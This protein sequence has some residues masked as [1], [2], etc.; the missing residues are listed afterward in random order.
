VASGVATTL[1]VVA[2]VGGW[3]GSDLPAQLF[4]VELFR[5]Y[6]FVLWDNQ[7]F[8]GH[9]TLGYSVIAP[10]F[11]AFTGPVVLGAVSGVAS[12]VLFDRIVHKSF[13]RSARLGSAW[14]ALSIVTNLVVGRVAFGLG[15]AFALAA[16]LLLQRRRVALAIV[17]AVA[18][19]LAS[20]VAAVFLAI[21][22]AATGCARADRRAGG[23]L[24]AVAAL[25][26]V[27]VIA[28]MFPSPGAEP[29]ELWALVCDLVLC[30]AVF[31][32]AP[33]D[34]HVLRWGASIYAV[35]VLGTYTIAT[36]LGGNV[37]R[38][39]QYIAGP[40]L[41]CLLWPRRRALLGAIAIPLLVWQ[42]LPTV[43]P[44]ALA[45]K[46]LSTHRAYYQPLL[47]FLDSQPLALGRVEI[48]A[49]YRHWETAYVAP[50]LSLARGWE[51]QLD[52]GYNPMF[53]D[54]TL[55]VDSY[56]QWLVNNGVEYVALP[57][58]PLDPSSYAEKDLLSNPPTYL[59]PVWHNADWHIWRFTQYRGLVDGPAQLLSLAPDSF[60]LQVQHSGAITVHVHASSHWAIQGVGCATASAAGWTELQDVQPGT[61]RVEQ[62]L[63]GSPCSRP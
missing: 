60:T 1:A 33:R 40:L 58:A 10:V 55:T 7:W 52:I 20:P 13:D 31:V 49:T 36:P 34:R 42:W 14:F 17:G 6:G 5:R 46:D 57:D 16:V 53:Y 39:N 18:C 61:V 35:A 32:F 51:R 30:V 22:A 26:P 21:G 37:S 9:P 2:I 23:W 48:P 59:R 50:Q 43:D 29:Y 15:V 19:A 8:G 38:L 25:S 54:G 41:A 44:I 4:R 11:G 62:T 63:R 24:V 28:I 56:R 47:T 3:R 12:A 45:G 27:L